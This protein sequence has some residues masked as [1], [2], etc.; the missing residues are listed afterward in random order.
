MQNIKISFMQFRILYNQSFTEVWHWVGAPALIFNL[1]ILLGSLAFSIVFKLEVTPVAEEFWVSLV[2]F[3]FSLLILPVLA[4][5]NLFGVSAKREE[6][7]SAKL[8]KWEG[9]GIYPDLLFQP[10][11]QNDGHLGIR[12]TNMED[13]NVENCSA[14]LTSLTHQKYK[15][16]DSFIGDAKIILE[17][18]NP[19]GLPLTWGGGSKG[20]R[21]SISRDGGQGL[22]N[23]ARHYNERLIFLFHGL[24]GEMKSE[25]QEQGVYE[26]EVWLDGT[27]QGKSIEDVT[28]KGEIEFRRFYKD[29]DGNTYS[30]DGVESTK[31][32]SED[33]LIG[34]YYHSEVNITLFD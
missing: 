1:I 16:L 9:E 25:R 4:F 12:I 31:I 19:N 22:I 28:V 2:V 5:I 27:I 15:N 34:E 3:I 17:D 32:Y 20:G 11:K 13:W 14:E 23:I 8:S 21:R 29:Q 33:Q 7:L 24:H 10:V 26:F 6:K 18:V 30:S